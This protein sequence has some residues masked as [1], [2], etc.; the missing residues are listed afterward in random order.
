MVFLCLFFETRDAYA[1][2]VSI[3][4]GNDMNKVLYLFEN[5]RVSLDKFGDNLMIG[6]AFAAVANT[7]GDLINLITFI[8]YF[9]L[10]AWSNQRSRLGDSFIL[11][12]QQY[13]FSHIV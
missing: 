5:V 12:T 11:Q 2:V 10:P 7:C 9:R 8:T 4:E 3:K 13:S 6:L 1:L